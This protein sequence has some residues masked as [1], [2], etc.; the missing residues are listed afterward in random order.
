[1]GNTKLLMPSAASILQSMRDIGYTLDTAVA[2]I[3]DNSIAAA[4][5][6]IDLIFTVKPSPQFLIIDNGI[7]MTADELYQA[8][9]FAT[10]SPV[11]NRS[12]EDLGRFG[13]GLK[14][15]SFSQ[16]RT[17]TV[18]SSKFGKLCA[19]QWDLD[20][21][22]NNDKWLLKIIDPYELELDKI[23]LDKIV[24]QGTIVL[25]DRIDRIEFP[26]N[27]NEA[28]RYLAHLLTKLREHL[29]LVFHKF[30]EGVAKTNKIQINLNNYEIEAFNPFC[31][32]NKFTRE[33]GTEKVFVNDSEVTIQ[34]Y[35]LPYYNN[36]TPHEY[37]TF[38]KRSDLLNC[39]GVYVYRNDRLMVWGD[40]F[41]I[42]PKSENTKYSR[43]EINF[44]KS[45][46]HLWTIDIKKSK[47]SPP[48]VVMQ[49]LRQIIG[50]I[51]GAS[52]KMSTT[53]VSKSLE[54]NESPWSRFS[55]EGIR[56]RV[57]QNFPLYQT[58]I[59]S[60]SEEQSK[61]LKSLIE[62]IESSLP[63]QSIYADMAVN[64]KQVITHNHD[65]DDIQKLKDKFLSFAD[66]MEAKNLDK[67][68]LKE[69][70]ISCGLFNE[71]LKKLDQWLEEY[72]A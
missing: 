72:Y 54:T 35:A 50:K 23:Y 38:K 66:F 70:S 13:L 10:K 31:V 67:K 11:E 2:D 49:R 29:G 56:Y 33:I 48:V 8:L 42:I 12:D 24:K 17:L 52:E 9:R 4:A 37:E 27:E 64:P 57:N 19:A 41:R 55:G 18:I 36:M 63:I 43:V 51:S 40:W 53:R 59:K 21:V 14:T 44:D 30:I 26:Q 39:Q 45:I 61:H 60:M 25:W 6:E 22:V 15:A 46:D 68:I 16:A 3:I 71:H 28:Q 65:D 47:A 34:A 32:S 58:L 5:T 62:V 20:Y 7:G 1:M 69:A